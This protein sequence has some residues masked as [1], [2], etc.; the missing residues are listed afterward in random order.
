VT[1]EELI[2]E[3]SFPTVVRAALAVMRSA[4]AS[5]VFAFSN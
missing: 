5:D 2:E 3:L 4:E 1:D